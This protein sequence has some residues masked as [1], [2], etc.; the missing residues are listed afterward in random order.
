M[1]AKNFSQITRKK[2]QIIWIKV[3]NYKKINAIK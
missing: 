2:L 3:K 1:P